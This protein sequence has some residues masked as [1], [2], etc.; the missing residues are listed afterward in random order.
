[1]EKKPAFKRGAAA[2]THNTAH[3]VD[4]PTNIFAA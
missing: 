2:R 1:M 3:P 4:E